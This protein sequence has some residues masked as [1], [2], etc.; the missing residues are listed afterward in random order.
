MKDLEFNKLSAAILLAGVILMVISTLIDEVYQPDLS[1]RKYKSSNAV[2]SI[3]KGTNTPE[4]LDIP[5]LLASARV[6]KGKKIAVRCA[7]CHTF[8]KD[9]RNAVGPNLWGIV[10]NKKAHLGDKF[11]YST[12]MLKKGGVWNYTALFHFLHKP[13]SYVP[14]T[15]MSF[16]GLSKSQE[17]ADVISYLR[18]MSDN[19][20]PL[21]PVKT[22]NKQD[23]EKNK[24]TE[25]DKNNSKTMKP[26]HEQHNND[27]QVNEKKTANTRKDK[28]TTIEKKVPPKI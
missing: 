12:A 25:Q 1:T 27:K 10:G 5:L 19:P 9:E 15:R 23:K 22:K 18:T 20:P 4:V 21:P 3:Q 6:D 13:Q 7:S 24:H 17:I 16:I 28:V 26:V 11:A 14:G 8:T 2:Q